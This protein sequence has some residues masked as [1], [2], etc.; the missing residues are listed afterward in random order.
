[1][2]KSLLIIN[3]FWRNLEV[4]CD[5]NM[6][7]FSDKHVTCRTPH[8]FPKGIQQFTYWLEHMK[9]NVK[10]VITETDNYRF[11]KEPGRVTHTT[12]T[13]NLY[14][15]K[16]YPLLNLCTWT[17]SSLL[18][19]IRVPVATPIIIFTPR[20][21]VLTLWRKSSIVL[22]S[23]DSRTKFRIIVNNDGSCCKQ[24]STI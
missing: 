6:F 13:N 20:Y 14:I 10:E 24:F 22:L 21:W 7:T 12:P 4:F 23:T 15:I 8:V 19:D 9:A 11:P 16:T 1:M 5:F 17:F 2:I 3:T 18:V